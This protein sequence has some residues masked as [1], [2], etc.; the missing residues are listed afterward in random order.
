MVS[1]ES[2]P[3]RQQHEKNCVAPDYFDYRRTLET[4]NNDGGIGS[5]HHEIPMLSTFQLYI[6]ALLNLLFTIKFTRQ[7][8]DVTNVFTVQ[9][10]N[11]PATFD[12]AFQQIGLTSTMYT[13]YERKH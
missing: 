4:V 6:L 12:T 7:F 10:L 5:F 11:N 8:S 2:M 13:Q 3:E 9:I 1:R